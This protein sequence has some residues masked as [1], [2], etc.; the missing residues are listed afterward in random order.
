MVHGANE[1]EAH[2]TEVLCSTTQLR[3]QT[4]FIVL[5]S[6]NGTVFVWHGNGCSE[7]IKEVIIQ[8]IKFY[9]VCILIFSNEVTIKI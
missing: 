3:S 2:L 1:D 9:S 8:T 4:S 5:D 6:K 7:E